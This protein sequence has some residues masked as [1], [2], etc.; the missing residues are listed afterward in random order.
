MFNPI[1]IVLKR[2]ARVVWRVNEDTLNLAGELLF[3][4]FEGEQI[5]AEDEAVI[6]VVVVRDPLLG[7]IR[8]LRVFEQDARLQP[9]PVLFPNP[10]QFQFWFARHAHVVADGGIVGEAAVGG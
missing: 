2:T 10:S 8:I 4:R 1:I 3:E 5:V 7:V 6:E 9:G